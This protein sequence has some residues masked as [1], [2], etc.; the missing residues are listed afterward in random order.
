[1][2]TVTEKIYYNIISQVMLIQLI[3]IGQFIRLCLYE[4][5]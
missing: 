3:L 5:I 2:Y 1:M 4:S